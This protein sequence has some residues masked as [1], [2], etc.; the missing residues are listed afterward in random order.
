MHL[1]CCTNPLERLPISD[2]GTIIII[3]SVENI[4]VCMCV[5]EIYLFIKLCVPKYEQNIRV[6]YINTYTWL[7]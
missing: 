5:T 7:V 2:T 4:P 3:C 6:S 1:V